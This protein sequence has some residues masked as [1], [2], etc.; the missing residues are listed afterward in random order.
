[1]LKLQIAENNK[2]K[3]AFTPKVRSASLAKLKPPMPKTKTLTT[4]HKQNKSVLIPAFN[5]ANSS[6]LEPTKSLSSSFSPEGKKFTKKVIHTTA[7][8]MLATSKLAIS[9][10][11]ISGKKKNNLSTGVSIRKKMLIDPGFFTKLTKE[12]LNSTQPA[13]SPSFFP[14]SAKNNIFCK[15]DQGFYDKVKGMFGRFKDRH[16]KI[17]KKTI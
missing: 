6:L 8:P 9:K 15:P 3:G 5:F 10:K 2:N 4:L 16:E 14:F 1:M 11:A 13:I 7:N 17:M 12:A